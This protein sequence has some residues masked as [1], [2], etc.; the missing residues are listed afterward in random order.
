M[1]DFV[2]IRLY[3]EG[4]ETPIGQAFEIE[5]LPRNVNALARKVKEECAVYLKHCGAIG[6]KVYPPGTAVPF[7]ASTVPLRAD[8]KVSDY[9]TSYDT[10]LIV[11][12]PKPEQREDGKLRCCYYIIDFLFRK[13]FSILL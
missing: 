1:T 13:C 10:P 3:Y 8:K 11:V 2:W 4:E 7:P 5:P 6:L 12:A 9:P